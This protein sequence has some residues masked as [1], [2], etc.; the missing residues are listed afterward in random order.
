MQ[1]P[2]EV[3]MWIVIIFYDQM[4][5]EI[6][7]TLVQAFPTRKNWRPI[8]LPAVTETSIRARSPVLTAFFKRLP[9]R[10]T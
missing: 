10:N 7:V 5:I 1:I 6:W 9:I 8:G 4:V 2:L 3:P